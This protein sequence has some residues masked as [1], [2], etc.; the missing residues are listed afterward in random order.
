M[1]EEQHYYVHTELFLFLLKK[2]FKLLVQKYNITWIQ[3]CQLHV[4]T[5][6]KKIISAEIKLDILTEQ[7]VIKYNT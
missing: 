1:K 3:D 5:L 2:L 6:A 7:H 4:M